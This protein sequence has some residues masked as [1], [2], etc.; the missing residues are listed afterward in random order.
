MNIEIHYSKEGKKIIP[1]TIS[2]H[3]EKSEYFKKTY[4]IQ[5]N[6]GRIKFFCDWPFN[7]KI[8][9][10]FTSTHTNI[11]ANYF[12]ITKFIFDDFWESV[13][14]TMKG[15]VLTDNKHAIINDVENGNFNSMF[16]TGT[17]RYSIPTRPML[18]WT[19]KL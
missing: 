9:L 16:Y 11:E 2:L 13:D 10:D 19:T 7:T 15:A 17:L 3:N 4:I 6:T 1:I 12:T 14:L 5:K 8:N 18:N